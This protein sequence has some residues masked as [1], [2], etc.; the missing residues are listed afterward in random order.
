[1]ATDGV[2]EDHVD[3][4]HYR[5]LVRRLLE[6]EDVDLGRAL[7]LAFHQ[8]DVGGPFHL[9][10]D[11]GDVALVVVRAI[12]GRPDGRLAGDHGYHLEIGH[13]AHVVQGEDV[14]GIGHGQGDLVALPPDGQHLVLARNL[15]RHELE[16]FGIDVEL[17]EGDRLD[18]VLARQKGDQ[19]FFGD[20]V[21]L[22]E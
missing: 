19:L 13:E 10:D 21:E 5:R 7:F 4:A 17:G 11:V 14:G 18:T 20:E 2:H 22:D 6:L 8:L 9:G 3:E 16:H 1:S 15:L 12:D